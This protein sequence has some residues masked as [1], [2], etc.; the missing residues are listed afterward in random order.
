MLNDVDNFIIVTQS[1]KKRRYIKTWVIVLFVILDLGAASCLLLAY[2]PSQKFKNFLV[3]TAMATMNHKYLARTIYSEKTIN[4][5]LEANTIVELTENTN[6]EAITIGNYETHTYE[7][8]YEEQIL[9]KENEN[10][11]YKIIKYKGFESTYYITA[12]Y[13]PSRISLAESSNPGVIGETVKKIAS[14]N[15]AV[16]AMNASGFEDRGGQGNG[17]SATG[18]VIKDGKVSWVGRANRWGGGLVGFNKEHKLVLTRDS[19]SKAIK[20]GMVDAVTFGPFLIVNGKEADVLGNGGT[21]RQPRSIIAQRQD[22]IVLFIVVDGN[23]NKV[24]YRGGT[25]YKEMIDVLKKYKAYN[26]SNLDGGA[27]SILIENNKIIN[28]PVGYGETGERN[29]PNAWILK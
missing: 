5:V 15:K 7:S 8:K 27:S 20:D 29:H 1:K 4:E 11:L 19:A 10:D 28:N 13:D 12:I 14:N 6:T 2:G 21:G 23:G 22:G 25:D 24:G 16:L 26:A 18:T 9:K 3:T 17:A